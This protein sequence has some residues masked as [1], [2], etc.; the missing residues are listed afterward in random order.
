MAYVD[1]FVVPVPRSKVKAYLE[2]ARL[3]GKLWKKHGAVEY[4]ECVGDDLKPGF[5]MPFLKGI[6]AR[7]NETVFFS[8]IVYRSKAHRNAVNKRVMKDPSMKD[9]PKEMPF[10]FKRMLYGGFN[11]VVDPFK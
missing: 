6:R 9:M 10:D 11:A 1:G 3:G 5:G 2:M 4:R 8:Y 7:P